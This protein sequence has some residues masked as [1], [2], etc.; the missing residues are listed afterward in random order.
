MR[1]AIPVI[2]GRLSSHFGHCDVFALFD[3]DPATRSIIN[4]E[5]I[6]APPHQPGLLPQWL[7]ERGAN[8]IIAGGMGGRALELCGRQGIAVVLGAPEDPPE[9]LVNEFLA[10][11]LHTGNNSCDH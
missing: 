11:N 9:H 1:I 4:R 3:A 2:Q 10:G 7:A 5:E 8:I 6:D